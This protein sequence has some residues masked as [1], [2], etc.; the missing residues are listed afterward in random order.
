MGQSSLLIELISEGARPEAVIGLTCS[1][2]S[3][4]EENVISYITTYRI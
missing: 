2:Q 1:G 4:P 3:P